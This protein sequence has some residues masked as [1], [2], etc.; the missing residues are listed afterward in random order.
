MSETLAEVR[1]L[2]VRGEV[3]VSV[4]GY[5]EIAADDILLDDIVAG[6]GAAIL[7]E[8]YPA[9][10]KGP[11]VLVLQHDGE[12]RPI[13]VVWGIPMGQATPA[14]LVT[15]YRPDTARWTRDFMRRV[16]P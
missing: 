15:A 1:K 10:A 16:K 13:H 11:C 5:R 9:F 14:V 3:R 8:D 2:V 4:H 6:I 7:V 12:S